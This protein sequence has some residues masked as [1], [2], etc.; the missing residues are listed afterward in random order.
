MNSE[1]SNALNFV[2][3][4]DIIREQNI[5]LNSLSNTVDNL[6]NIGLDINTEIVNQNALLGDMTNQVDNTSNKLKKNVQN[7]NALLKKNDGTE[8]K[9]YIFLF[10]NIRKIKIIFFLL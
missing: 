4:D 8:K 2:Q 7:M 9:N 10:A 1:V 3:F 5:Q 6:Q